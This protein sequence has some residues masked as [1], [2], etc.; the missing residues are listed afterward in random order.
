MET[1]VYAAA[2]LFSVGLGGATLVMLWMAAEDFGLL[3]T[4]LCGAIG[5]PLIGTLIFLLFSAIHSEHSPIL[6]TLHK[7][8]WACV[9]SHRQTVTTYV[10]VGK[11]M[12]PV[13]SVRRVC[14]QYARKP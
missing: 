8:E 11:V 7:G 1:L 5:L 10:L 9:E 3:G 13:T 6:A 12:T 14:D 2:F 4:A